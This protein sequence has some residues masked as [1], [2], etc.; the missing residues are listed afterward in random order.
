MKPEKFRN[1]IDQTVIVQ[2]VQLR[3]L[4]QS[5]L[6]EIG[7]KIQKHINE[8]WHVQN[9]PQ[10]SHNSELQNVQVTSLSFFRNKILE[11][12]GKKSLQNFEELLTSKKRIKELDKN[13][14][15]NR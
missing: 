10:D 13:R 4:T 9:K 8:F 7:W 1:E 15:K 12:N 5:S 14:M 6:W 11:W 3:F 2:V